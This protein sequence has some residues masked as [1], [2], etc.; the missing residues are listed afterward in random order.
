MVIPTLNEAENVG[1][2]LERLS[3][4]PGVSEVVVSDGGSTDGTQRIVSFSGARLVEA[5]PGRGAQLRAGAGEASGDVLLFL[6]ADVVPPGDLAAQI[7]GALDLGCVGGNFRLRY[8][9]GGALGRWLE[10]L[11]PFYRKL[12]RYY[13]DSGIFVRTSV[14]DEIGGFPQIP[15]ME[16]M[17][18]ARRLEAAGKTAY[19]PGPMVSASRRWKGRP[20]RTLLLWA[21]MQSAFALGASPHEL[22]RFY[23]SHG[24]G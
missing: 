9:Q 23:R 20:A 18:F 17:V 6:H 4:T 2:L 16:D 14:H 24:K 15:I 8:P 5:E 10:A 3:R 13:G 1:A 7:E 19:L 12:G 22:A 21:F 11:A